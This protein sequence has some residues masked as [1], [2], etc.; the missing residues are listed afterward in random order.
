MKYIISLVLRYIIHFIMAVISLFERLG[1]FRLGLGAGFGV[2]ASVGF[3]PVDGYLQTPA[4]GKPET[5]DVKRPTLADLGIRHTV[6]T[7]FEASW[8]NARYI[9]Y[10]GSRFI[11][12]SKTGVLEKDLLSRTQFHA[13]EKFDAKIK[14][15]LYRAGIKRRFKYFAPKTEYTVMDFSY[16]LDTGRAC[17]ERAYMKSAVRAGAEGQY[18]F[19][20]AGARLEFASSIPLPNTPTIFTTGA[21]FRYWLVPGRFSLGAGLSYLYLDYED[22]QEF[23]NHLRLEMKPILTVSTELRF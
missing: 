20:T 12:I 23:S 16:R 22:Y 11:N 10:I 2:R 14:F 8:T 13:G 3:A 6:F 18:D 17:M 1:L 19:G 4:G 5:S 15:N 7:D 9:V 21:E